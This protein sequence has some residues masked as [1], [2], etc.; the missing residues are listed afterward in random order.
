MAN[1][2]GLNKYLTINKLIKQLS[3]SVVN[4]NEIY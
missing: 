4:I 2:L 3:L 1:L